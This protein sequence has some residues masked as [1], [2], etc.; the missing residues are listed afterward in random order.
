MALTEP[1]VGKDTII[2]HPEL[3]VILPCIIGVGCRIHAPVWIGAN[4]VIG[5]NCRVQAFSF[6]PEGVILH[7]NVFIGPRVTFTN[8]KYPPATKDDWLPTVVYAG[9]SIGAGAI[10]L[11]GVEIGPG[12]RI[13]AGAVITKSVP[14]GET[15]VGNPARVIRHRNADFQEIA[16]GPDGYRMTM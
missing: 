2:Y 13:G 7:N 4:V 5:N 9:A 16:D 8:D 6:I 14:A 15:W 1:R 3:S 11:P 12:A 10:I